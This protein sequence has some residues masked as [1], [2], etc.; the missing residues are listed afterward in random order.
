[1]AQYAGRLHRLHEGK[2]E[3]CIYD[4]ADLNVP[5]LSRMFDKRCHGYEALGYTIL[6]PA[7]AI[8]RW[9][10]EVPLPVEPEW[11][12]DYAASIRRLVRDGVDVPLA[13]LFVHAARKYADD[14]EGAAHARSTSKA[15]LFRRLE[16]LPEAVGRFCLNVVLP[17]PFDGMNSMEVDLC[18]SDTRLAIE[19]DGPH[20]FT[21]MEAYRRDRRKDVLLQQGIS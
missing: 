6:L 18:C 16:T 2:R 21:N 19:L 5:M 4:Y 13:N 12:H 1:M 7:S 9:P 15:F 11:K 3:V 17:I 8:P 10:Q 14:A 20:H